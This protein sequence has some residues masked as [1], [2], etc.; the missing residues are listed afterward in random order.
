[1][2]RIALPVYGSYPQPPACPLKIPDTPAGL[3]SPTWAGR[4][5][6]PIVKNKALRIMIARVMSR[7]GAAAAEFGFMALVLLFSQAGY[8]EVHECDDVWRVLVGV[9]VD[10]NDAVHSRSI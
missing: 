10:H 5:G 6:L 3:L 1:M 2:T 7:R 9:R 4:R 8:L